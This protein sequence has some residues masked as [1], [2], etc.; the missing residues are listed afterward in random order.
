[1]APPQ[2]D[3]EQ[4]EQSI[5][6][7]VAAGRLTASAADN[8]RPWLRE[9]YYAAYR[10]RLAELIRSGQYAEI[11]RLF[12]EKIPFGTGGRRGP[13]AEL[14]SATINPRTI[15]ESA[16]GL[17]VYVRQATGKQDCRAVIAC[18]TRHR[19]LEFSRVCA[20]VMAAQ[21]FRVFRFTAPRATPELSF[22]VRSLQCD[23]GIMISASHNPPCDNGFKA[24]WSTGGQVLAPHDQGIIACVEAAGEIPQLDFD[25][26]LRE[27]RIVPIDAE[28]DEAYLAA[29][30]ALSLSSAREI[31]AVF[32]PLHGVGETSVYR[33][34]QRAG[35]RG[36]RLYEP[37]CSQDGAFPNVPD[38]LPNPERP[39]VFRPA[40]EAAQ[41]SDAALILA[42]DPDA[43]RLAVAVRGRDG[44]FQ[45]LTGNQLGALLTDYILRKR[46]AAGTLSPRHFVVE[47]LVTTPLIAAVARSYGVRVIDD[48]LVGFKYIGATIDAEGPDDFVF[49]VEESLGYLAGSYARDKD[50]AVAALY[51]LELAAELRQEGQ[52]LLDRLAALFAA[53]GTYLED[54][55]S[56]TCPGPQGSQQIAR[57]MQLF[58][59]RP[60]ERI[61]SIRLER[62]NDYL[63]H[64]VRA[65]PGNVRTADLPKPSG[66]V[67]MAEGESNGCRVRIALRPSGTE[68][69]IKFYLFVHRPA[70]R[71]AVEAGDS[72]RVELER[73]RG[74]VRDWAGQAIG[75][76]G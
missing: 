52:T 49:G 19:S 41:S 63:R 67:L 50:A 69:K 27:G 26:G 15:A 66:D 43:D 57:L 17:A 48:L 54:Q 30:S 40:I 32:T 74:A 39:E 76:G 56:W 1:M 29:V 68:P 35:F 71:G 10:D 59:A 65:L 5:R 12:W 21:G 73:V 42:S 70:S 33:V 2:F 75:N 51:A 11:D 6:A 61:G 58:R 64:E 23:T 25:A 16:Y 13:M 18:D 44:R 9:P 62:V 3:P 8:L 34:L 37:Q 4:L 60:P 38:H 7:A 14:G 46:Q 20:S 53:H 72:A 24:Y 31:P 47:T 22:A 36:V 55:V 28:V 45:T